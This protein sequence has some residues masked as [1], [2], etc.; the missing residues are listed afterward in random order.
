MWINFLQSARFPIIGS[1][2]FQ[3]IIERD[4]G[5]L[6]SFFALC[7]VFDD[8]SLHFLVLGGTSLK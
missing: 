3:G 4:F 6:V 1:G 2:D 5:N 7:S 8:A